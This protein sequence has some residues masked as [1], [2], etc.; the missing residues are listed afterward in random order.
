MEGNKVK[1]GNIMVEV[2]DLALWRD[3][4]SEAQYFQILRIKQQ[5]PRPKEFL[6]I[7]KSKTNEDGNS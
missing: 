2:T 6:S 5:K 4:K 3:C 1:L 7:N